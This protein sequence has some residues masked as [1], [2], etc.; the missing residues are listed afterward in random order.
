M[1]GATRA[2]YCPGL[3]GVRVAFLFSAPGRLEERAGAPVAGGTG[4]NLDD[5]LAWL[6]RQAPG[7]F[8]SP[9]RYDYRVT[10]AFAEVLYEGKHGRTEASKAEILAPENLARVLRELEGVEAV[11]LCGGRAC[12]V[13]PALESAGLKVVE[14]CH[15]GNRGL[16]GRYRT[17]HPEVSVLATGSERRRKRAEL[18]GAD[19]LAALR[20]TGTAR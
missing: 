19:V 7:L 13:K 14:A 15:C 9:R 4:A 3:P 12:L 8:P 6:H 17:S 10:N 18:W 20:A 5:A 1:A 16:V 2:H 11:V